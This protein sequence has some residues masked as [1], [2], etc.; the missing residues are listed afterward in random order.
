MRRLILIFL[1]IICSKGVSQE[2]FFLHVHGDNFQQDD[3]KQ[4]TEFKDSIQVLNFLRERQLKAQKKGYLL[5]SIDSVRFNGKAVHAYFFQGPLLERIRINCTKEDLKFLKK[6]SERKETA[7]LFRDLTPD[8]TAGFMEGLLR[9]LLGSGYPFASIKLDSVTIT[10][11]AIEGNLEMSTGPLVRWT[12]LHIKGDSLIS[13]RLISSII[14]IRKNDL[15]NEALFASISDKIRQTPYL[16]EIKPAEILFTKDGAELFLYL[17]SVPVSNVNGMIGLQQDPATAR[18][19]VTG[20]V[21]LKLTNVL[22]RGE[23]LFLNWRS[24]QPGIQALNTNLSY[25]FLFGT[26]FGLDGGFQLYKRDTSFLETRSLFGVLYTLPHGNQIKAFYQRHG[27]SVLSSGSSLPALSGFVNNA[28]GVAFNRRSVDYLPNPSKGLIVNVETAVGNRTTSLNDSITEQTTTMRAG[29]QLTWFL[30]LT[31]RHVFKLGSSFETYHAPEIYTNE[32]FRFGGLNTLRGFNEEELFATTKLIGSVEYRFL[33]DKNSHVFLFYDQSIY[34]KRSAPYLRDLPF[35]F[36]GGFSFG[37][38][39]G[40][41][42]ISYALG[43]Q[44]DNPI[45]LRNGKVHFGYIAYF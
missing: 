40:I 43:K 23:Q 13:Q 1:L 41:F 15:Y 20:D 5:A 34:E 16:Q 29:L 21:S 32:L 17:K 39:L 44:F 11:T 42:S 9:S 3:R 7:L 45:Q 18:T 4:R 25:P 12:T 27:S 14:Q 35:G 2:S 6:V 37:T 28:Y 8:E 19:S 22:R 31:K 38:N 33:T 24:I 10:N 30:P 26:S 36:G